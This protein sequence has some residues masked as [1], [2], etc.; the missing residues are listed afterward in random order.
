MSIPHQTLSCFDVAYV[1]LLQAGRLTH[2][3]VRGGSHGLITDAVQN[4]GLQRHK[5]NKE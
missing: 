3:R 4:L 5:R 1:D 2:Q